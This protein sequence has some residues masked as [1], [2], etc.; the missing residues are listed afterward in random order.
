M[1][2]HVG[3]PTGPSEPPT[4]TS[5]GSVPS[6]RTRARRAAVPALPL[7]SIAAAPARTAPGTASCAQC[8]STALT[9]LEMTLTDGSPVV[10]VSCHDCEHK[11]WFAV[12]GTGAMLSF[13]SVLGSATKVR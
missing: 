9:H 8:G 3:V 7:G 13:Q 5:A 11:G 2:R 4:P 1:A 12:D 10:F 6:Q